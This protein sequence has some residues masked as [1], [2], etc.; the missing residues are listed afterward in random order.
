M[1]E[2][3]VPVVAPEQQPA[4]K[5]APPPKRRVKSPTILQMEAVECG[6]A[7]LA[8]VLAYHGRWVPL[9]EL[10][11]ECGVSRDGSK[12]NN[13]LRAAR[14]YGL[15]AKGFK[16]DDLEKLYTLE[17]PIILFWNFN[18]FVVLDGFAGEKVQIN[19]PA[20]G[21]RVVTM[22]ELD[23]SYSGVVLT[24]KKGAE[25]KKGGSSPKMVPALRRRLI[26]HERALLFAILCGLCL[27]I[28]G[29]VIPTF[30]R[31]FIDNYLLAGQSW[32]VKPLLW[33]MAATIV[34]HGALTFLQKYV[35]LRLETKMSLVTSSN[36]FNHILR[37]PAAYFAQ[38]FSG[39]IGSRVLI[40]DKV[41]MM[42]SRRFVATVIDSIMTVFYAGLMLT[43]D[44]ALTLIVIVISLL[45]VAAV[46]ISARMRIDLTRRLMQDRGKLMG[47]SMNGLQMM[48]TLKATGSENEFFGRWAGYYAK[49]VNTDQSLQVIGQV[50]GMVP[51]FVQ[52]L[53]TA[54]IL[55]L[56]G[57]K[58]MS[59]EMTVG[60]LVAYQTLLSS[61]TRPLTSFVQFGSDIQEMQAD[62]NRLDDVIRYPADTQYE[63]TREKLEFEGRQIKLS[64]HIEL[65]D[66]TFGNSPLDKPLIENFNLTVAPG[67][68]VA[69]V[70]GSG[71]GKST[72][73]KIASGLYKPWSGEIL[74]DGIPRERLPRDLIANS[75]SVVD[76]E[77]FLFG[78][79]VA[80]NVTMWD[81][82]V[83]M[84]RISQSSRDAAIDDV[85]EAREGGYQSKVQEG[86]GNY[87]GGQCQRLE[88][89][90]SL[91]GEPT[92]MILDEATSALDPHTEQHIDESLRR[93]GCT[94]IIIA[95]RLSTIRDADE[96]IVMERGKIVQRGTHE[97]LKAVPG[98]YQLLMMLH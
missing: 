12:A 67:R 95:H 3:P 5:P 35:L 32:M 57:M 48:E 60:M 71:S 10:R 70:G 87:S 41:A 36:F 45:N 8:M 91:V 59:G 39:E 7:A 64:G 80:E 20:Q 62:M 76:Q 40:N 11:H 85:I 77:V 25:F 37:L 74:F 58:V 1:P 86:G 56:G 29:L 15:E 49:T 44:V 30:T 42:V 22:D 61:F 24:F 66:I 31:V 28:P 98:A 43:Y 79:T 88:I 53:S 84:L 81:S 46:R 72:V 47:T 51:M 18:H 63:Q 94:C 82:T 52:T 26:G 2:I 90:R 55:V 16:Y 93:R 13:V 9:E 69:L 19:D 65:R 68:R 54:S 17:F 14:K 38:R 23:G 89:S 75:L 4:K 27:V 97:Q 73:A 6:A 78:G 83:P 34:V 33:A 96:I 21:P 92:I 50:Q